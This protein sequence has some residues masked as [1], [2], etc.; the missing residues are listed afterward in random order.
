M[1][2]G[3]TL[4]QRFREGLR[5]LEVGQQSESFGIWGARI[6]LDLVLGEEKLGGHCMRER[7]GRKK[8][9]GLPSKNLDVLEVNMENFRL[10]RAWGIVH[11]GNGK[12]WDLLM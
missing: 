5:A 4:K 11:L 6:P 7:G 1:G 9:L 3:G 2:E 8:G 10:G 12:S